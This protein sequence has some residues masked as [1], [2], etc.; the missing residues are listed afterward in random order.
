VTAARVP[1]SDLDAEGAVLSAC[2]LERDAVDKCAELL[3]PEH[4]YSE[5]NRRI[6]EAILALAASGKP[7]DLVTVAGALRDAGRLAQVGGSPY[8]A[9]VQ[10]STPSVANV[11]THAATVRA[12]ARLREMAATCSRLAA[13]AYGDVG[14]VQDFIDGAEADVYAVARTPETTNVVAIR[15]LVEDALRVVREAAARGERLTGVATGFD[16]LDHLTAGLHDGETTIVA[17]RPGMGK[18]GLALNIAVNVAGAERKSRRQGVVVF[19]LEMPRE[20]LA[21]RLLCTEAGVNLTAFRLG[22]LG[23]RDWEQLAAAKE[24]L[25]AL[26]IWIDDTPAATVGALRARVRRLQ[27]EYD[28]PGQRIGLVV[29]DYLQLMRAAATQNR[30]RNR[31]QE[32]SEI[33]QGLKALA[34]E[35]R[36]PVVALSQLN[37]SCE[38]RG[39][40]K[41]PQLSDLRESGAI[42]QDADNIVFIYREDY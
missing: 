36:V 5:A 42:E 27:A 7:V 19:S 14:S 3:K 6:Y 37:R 22:H 18:T 35:L 15:P 10:D 8:L 20:Q 29:V 1:P 28:G 26:P 21:H 34:K 41:R 17:A 24:R 9:M 30:G 16:D 31:E 12:K 38:I 39:G 11:E 33:S 13:E 32:I 40:D 25:A 23:P 2:L 4:F